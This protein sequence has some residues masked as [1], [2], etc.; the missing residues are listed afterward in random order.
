MGDLH[1]FSITEKGTALMTIYESVEGTYPGANGDEWTG[2][3]YD[4]L[5]QEMDIETGDLIFE[6]RAT[7]H[8]HALDSM[9]PP[10]RTGGSDN[11]GWDFFHVNSIDKN[12]DGDYL[13]S[14]RHMCAVACI[15]HVDGHIM[16]QLGGRGN[17]FDDLSDGQATNIAWNHHASYVRGDAAHD[18]GKG[19]NSVLVTVFDNES[20][21]QFKSGT[22]SR[23]LMV[24]LDLEAMTAKLAREYLSPIGYLAP[25]QGSV[26]ILPGGT[27]LVGWG[28]TPAYTEFTLE[29]EVLCDV[30]FGPIWFANFGWVKSYRDFKFPW[31]GRPDTRP[32]AAM[33]PSEQ[34][35]YVSWNG[36]TEVDRWVLQSAND[37]SLEDSQDN[38]DD[39]KEAS[40][41]DAA[42]DVA[43]KTHHAVRKT[44]FE[45]KMTLPAD[46]G[47]YVRAVALDASG[48]R[49]GA[50]RTVS[51]HE[52][53]V[54]QLTEAPSRGW[55]P[56]PITIFTWSLLAFLMTLAAVHHYRGLLRRVAIGVVGRVLPASWA[57]SVRSAH[58]YE[59]VP[60]K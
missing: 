28:H 27:V 26:Q 55:K 11:S 59:P 50:T 54:T 45:T 19:N 2:W 40:A 60:L 17:S 44:T 12:D 42:S 14:A 8:Y 5:I 58:K 24:E 3:L 1:E 48:A 51:R 56:E 13:I 32:D 49:L 23:G 15:S 18:S 46:A 47:E 4:C 39:K 53:T 37:G 6:W 20:N 43:Y 9:Q 57:G 41:A 21:G 38:E 22:H 34:A 35:L 16:W 52:K 10:G 33:R 29:G 7:D 31:V 36:A 30:H 25:S